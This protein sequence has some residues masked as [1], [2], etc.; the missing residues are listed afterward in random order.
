LAIEKHGEK[1]LKRQDQTTR[2]WNEKE[3]E[4]NTTAVNVHVQTVVF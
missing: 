4:E 3:T 1:T 2:K